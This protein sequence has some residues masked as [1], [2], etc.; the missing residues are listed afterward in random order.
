MELTIFARSTTNVIRICLF[1]YQ[2]NSRKYNP[3]QVDR[4]KR[5]CLVLISIVQ[6]KE[7]AQEIKKQIRIGIGINLSKKIES[8][9]N[10]Q[11]AR[12]QPTDKLEC[13]YHYIPF[14][15]VPCR[16]LMTFLNQIP[17]PSYVA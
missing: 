7:G 16:L 9:A 12:T 13:I 15:L 14:L 10:E 4:H 11:Q 5:E 8:K 3:N 1:F 2:F 17:P 6:K